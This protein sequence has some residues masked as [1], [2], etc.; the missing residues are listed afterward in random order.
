MT[1]RDPEPLE[2]EPSAELQAAQEKHLLE[3]WRTP[4]G[5]RY[6]S[7]VNNTEVGLWYTATAFAFLVFGGVLA[8]M[9]RI[10][11]AV[12]GNDFMTA[13][14]Y[15]QVFT[16]H[17][18]VMVFWVAMPFLVSGFGNYLV[19]LMVGA[20]DMSFPRLNMMSYWTFFISTGLL[21]ASFF[22]PRFFNALMVPKRGSSQPVNF[23][24]S[25]NS[26]A[27]DVL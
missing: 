2:R 19:H 18:T 13:E 16:M 6:W 9:I 1:P 27:S 14:T 21:I 7:E 12:P 4:T 25:I 22:M 24:S 10:Q 20:P 17:G 26:L 5:W 15:N 8:L 11:L 3:A 23:P